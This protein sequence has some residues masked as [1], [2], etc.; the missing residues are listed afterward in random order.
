MYSGAIVGSYFEVYTN[1]ELGRGNFSVGNS[2]SAPN[3]VSY[4]VLLSYTNIKVFK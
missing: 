4:L 3:T 2:L 1:L